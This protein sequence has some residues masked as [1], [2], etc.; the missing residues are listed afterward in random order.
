MGAHDGPV[1]A[2]KWNPSG[3]LLLS[4]SVDKTAT[5]WEPASGAVRQAFRFHSAPTLDVDWRDDD[6]FASCSTDT[7][8]HVCRLGGDAPVA[9]FRGHTDEVNAIK[10]S[11]CGALLA[12]CGDDCTAKIWSL[13]AAGDG[14]GGLLHDL[15]QHEKARG[16]AGAL[17]RGA[18]AG[19]APSPSLRAAFASPSN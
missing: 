7:A 4:G 11:P 15:T 5:V 6:T 1:F 16:A 3:T 12:S 8:I 18:A 10:W 19:A 14:R 17:P 2:L 9:T 13:A